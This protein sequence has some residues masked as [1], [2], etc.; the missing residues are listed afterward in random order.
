MN[1]SP[2]VR[3]SRVGGRVGGRGR[4]KEV[5]RLRCNKERGRVRSRG[6]LKEEPKERKVRVSGS[7][8][9]VRGW[10]N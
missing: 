5:P 6:W 7:R 3:V 4:A 2:R 10:L 1:E 8:V 9:A